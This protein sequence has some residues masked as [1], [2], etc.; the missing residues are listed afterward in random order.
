MKDRKFYH[1]KPK[2]LLGDTLFPQSFLKMRFPEIYQEVIEKYKDRFDIL[3]TR[4]PSLSCA[5]KVDGYLFFCSLA[6]RLTAQIHPKKQQEEQQFSHSRL[7]PGF[8]VDGAILSLILMTHLRGG[9]FFKFPRK[10]ASRVKNWGINE[11]ARNLRS[12]KFKEF[13]RMNELV[14]IQFKSSMN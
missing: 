8:F 1:F 11:G 14:Q 2:K 10:A 13:F 12:S 3:D 4:I 6:A 5:W 9:V 7:S